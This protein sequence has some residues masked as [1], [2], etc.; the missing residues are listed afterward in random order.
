MHMQASQDSALHFASRQSQ[1]VSSV[2]LPADPPAV[3]LPLQA[4]AAGPAWLLVCMSFAASPP[5]S[6]STA[7]V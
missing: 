7:C 2:N 1:S 5:P 6:V 4:L 3:T